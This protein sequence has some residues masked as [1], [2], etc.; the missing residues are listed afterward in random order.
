MAGA[1]LAKLLRREGRYLLLRQ[2]LD[3]MNRQG[4]KLLT[5]KRRNMVRRQL[6]RRHGIACRDKV[7]IQRREL[8]GIK[9]AELD[10]S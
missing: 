2:R 5:R 1:E 3:L 8:R 4:A 7:G 6:C 9:M 10:R